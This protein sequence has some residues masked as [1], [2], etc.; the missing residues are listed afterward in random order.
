MRVFPIYLHDNIKVIL[1]LFCFL[2][3]LNKKSNLVENLL[4]THFEKNCMHVVYCDENITVFEALFLHY[5]KIIDNV[6]LPV[7][8]YE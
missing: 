1:L 7:S 8:E 6:F 2:Y 5:H 4:L 3:V